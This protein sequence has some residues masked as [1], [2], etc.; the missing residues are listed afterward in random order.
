MLIYT[1]QKIK[2]IKTNGSLN[3]NI[4]TYYSKYIYFSMLNGI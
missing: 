2:N 4:P 1:M 3:I